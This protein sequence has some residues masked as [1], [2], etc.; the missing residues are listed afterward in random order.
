MMTDNTL[1]DDASSRESEEKAQDGVQ[2]SA[3][4]GSRNRRLSATRPKCITL[5]EPGRERIEAYADEQGLNFSAAIEM[6]AL[7]GLEDEG[8]YYLVP[9]LRAVALQGVRLA[10]NRMASL[11]SDIAIEAAAARTMSDAVMLQLIR[12]MAVEYPDDFV[13]RM[14]VQRGERRNSVDG[15]VRAFHE[16][17]KA[18]VEEEAVRRLKKAVG[19]VE[20]VLGEKEGENEENA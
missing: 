16:Q 18:G 9:A 3:Q 13:A 10:F 5:T 19:R 2:D 15:R 1:P 8:M 7:H 14:I 17:V 6:L 20:A 12:E 4:S 11:L